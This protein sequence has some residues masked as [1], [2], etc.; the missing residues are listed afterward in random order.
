MLSFHIV[1]INKRHAVDILFFLLDS[2][3]NLCVSGVHLSVSSYSSRI[4]VLD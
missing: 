3:I 4:S 1:F 2:V